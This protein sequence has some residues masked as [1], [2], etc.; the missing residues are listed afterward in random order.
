MASTWVVEAVDVLE[1]GGLCLT[2]GW[3]ILA[4][5]HFSL[6]A[7]EEGLDRR[8]VIAIALARHRGL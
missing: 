7:F 8:V 5:K 1:D 3:P 6:Q 4:P 2:S